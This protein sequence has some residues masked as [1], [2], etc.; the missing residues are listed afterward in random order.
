MQS[1]NNDFKPPKSERFLDT[2]DEDVFTVGYLQ[3]SDEMSSQLWE[4]I[5]AYIA[6]QV[7]FSKPKQ[8]LPEEMQEEEEKPFVSEVKLLPDAKEFIA[9]RQR[10]MRR[11][12]TRRV[13]VNPNKE[14]LRQLLKDRYNMLDRLLMSRNNNQNLKMLSAYRN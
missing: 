12:S 6:T 10:I 3:I 14:S 2:N 13:R 7:K 4:K 9:N 11:A 1:E 8:Q 5:S